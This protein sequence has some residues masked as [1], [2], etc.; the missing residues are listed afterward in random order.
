MSGTRVT[1]LISRNANGP[2]TGGAF[3]QDGRA[4]SL[5]AFTSAA[6]NLVGGDSNGALDVFVLHRSGMGGAIDRV[7]VASDG[8]QA[9]GD[10]SSPSVDGTNGRSPHCVAFQSNATNLDPRDTSPDSDVYVRNL[11]HG[12]TRVVAPGAT[13]AIH[14][15]ID[16]AC[17]LVTYEAGGTVFVAN[18]DGG[19][20][21]AIAQGSQPDQ[22]TDGRGVAYVRNG[23]VWYQRYARGRHGLA[24]RG[25]ERLVSAGL[26]GA[27]NGASAHRPRA[28][29]PAACADQAERRRRRGPPSPHATRRA[30]IWAADV[31]AVGSVA[32]SPRASPPAPRNRA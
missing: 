21:L 23:Q 32:T 1:A 2:S 22:E 15:T 11:A 5:Y 14:P 13:D 25:P 27:G 24:K 8:A 18:I 9:N 29:Y 30:R 6:T 3:S 10:S 7:S 28:A 20:P 31:A 19:A 26:S 4:A 16:G 17:Q 12:T